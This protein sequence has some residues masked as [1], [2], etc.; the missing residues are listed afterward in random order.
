MKR[1]INTIIGLSFITSSLMANMFIGVEYLENSMSYEIE[2]DYGNTQESDPVDITGTSLLIG[3]GSLDTSSFRIYYS[4]RES[5]YDYETTEYGFNHKIYF[6]SKSLKW[7][8]QYGLGLGEFETSEAEN[9]IIGDIGVGISYIFDKTIELSIGYD[10]KHTS[11][12]ESE[13][14]YDS[15]YGYSEEKEYTV[16]GTGSN[17]Y[18]GLSYWFGTTTNDV[19]K[20]VTQNLPTRRR[21]Y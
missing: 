5:E 13:Y 10:M 2:D 14:V 15:Y 3:W 18:I 21:V 7:S 12:T 6:G 9:Y 17:I 4:T 1:I 8:V 16:T 11:R 20:S 19:D